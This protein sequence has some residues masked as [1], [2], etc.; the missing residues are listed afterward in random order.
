MDNCYLSIV[1][2]SRNDDHGGNL[3]H[4]T[5]LFVNGLLEQC[6]R[7][8]LNAEL[9]MVEWNPPA[10]KPRLAE[11]LSWDQKKG[12]CSVR[13]IEVPPEI[14][15]RFKYSERL[16]LYQMI[17]KNV[18]IRRARGRFVLATNID[19]LF[20]DELMRFL[21][22]RKMRSEYFYR[23]ARYDIP[24]NVP[25]D[26]P[27]EEQL[28]FCRKNV[29]RINERFDTS[30]PGVS[31][32][33]RPKIPWTWKTW[34]VWPITNATRVLLYSFIRRGMP[35]KLK[36]RLERI[37]DRL[38]PNNLW[39]YFMLQSPVRLHTNA[40]GDFTLL[41]AERWAALRGHPELEMFS[42]HLDSLFCYLAHHSGVRE[43]VLSD[44][45]RIYHIEHGIGSG[46]TPEGAEVLYKRIDSAGIPRLEHEEMIELAIKMRRQ[47]RPIMFNS[48]NW[49][50]AND[51]LPETLVVEAVD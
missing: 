37:Q 28:D 30:V 50:L 3:I 18:G 45:M 35:D 6:R 24:S 49:G 1:V 23:V 39:R 32:K 17:A 2:T 12:P 13:I 26:M 4:R 20:S 11:V 31:S 42:M 16:P 36:Q 10:D 47:G 44:P 22:S 9:I 29:I 8:R 15:R 25:G 27:I 46:F 7:Y 40:C 48:E 5:Q 21:V 14:H 41:A 34:R 51:A 19:I 38:I 33:S 43:R